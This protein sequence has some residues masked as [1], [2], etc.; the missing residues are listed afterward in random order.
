MKIG[1]ISK[2]I[3][4]VVAGLTLIAPLSACG[5]STA[6]SHS[7][8]IN[9]TANATTAVTINYNPFSSL[10]LTG[11]KGGLYEALFFCNSYDSKGLQP[12][13]GKSYSISKDAKTIDVKLRTGVKWS[14][15][16]K[17]TVD[18]VVYTFNLL[19]KFSALNTVGFEGSV[20]K[21]SGS[22]VKIKFK[23][24][25]AANGLS[26]LIG[27]YI[28]PQHDWEKKKDPVTDT[29]KNAIGSGPLT[30]KGGKFESMNYTLMAN[31]NY[32]GGKPSVAGIRYVVYSSDQSK[33]DALEAG[34][35]DWANLN[36]VNS[37]SVLKGKAITTTNLPSS[38]VSLIT[39]SNAALGCS[40]PITDKAVRKAIYYALD[41]KQLNKL[42]FDNFYTSINGSLYP[43][44]QYQQYFD[45]T[46]ED[47]PTPMTARGSKAEQ[48]LKDAGYTKGSDGLYQKNGQ[49]LSFEVAVT[50]GT[51][52]W[53]NAIDV[54]NQQLKKIGIEFKTKQVSS[55][56]WGQGLRK[57]DYDLTI[58]GLWLPNA[59]EA[60]GFYN[61]WFNGAKTA[62]KGQTAYPGYARYNNPIVNSALKTI[63][64]TTNESVKKKAYTT[65]QKQ[66]FEDM[67]YIPILRQS[68]NTEF[69]SD[70]I[71]GFPTEDNLYANPQTWADPD[72]GIVFSHLKT[73]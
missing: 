48:L 73:K 65:I 49:K 17:V 36:I 18:D 20:E 60:Y 35:L 4:S 3:A 43:T 25:Q 1:K 59:T 5:G 66:V 54:M 42:A 40:G 32:W 62:R 39:C 29:N 7:V 27:V 21:V 70:K 51:S 68:G 72:V 46:V 58:Y 15:G 67:P 10:A 31:P 9:A 61:Q 52:A 16:K 47:S 38:Q 11:T 26:F 57:G 34:Q 24:P 41:R 63:N 71:T 22:E 55:N 33:Q 50:N 6:S 28:V 14:D 12:L 44:K 8:I 45:K 30:V 13:I 2:A 69:W 37:E 64:S 53:I 56:E 19:T 23:E